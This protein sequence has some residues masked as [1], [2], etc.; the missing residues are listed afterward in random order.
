MHI[1]FVLWSEK[2]ADQVKAEMAQY[3]C[4]QLRKST[5]VQAGEGAL[6]AKEDNNNITEEFCL[7]KPDL[8]R[9]Y[10]DSNLASFIEKDSLLL[11]KVSLKFLD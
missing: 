4:E 9:I 6:D 8:P 3:L 7:G 11:F 1:I 5:K 10:E 2:I